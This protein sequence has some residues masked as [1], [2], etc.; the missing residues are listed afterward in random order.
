[1]SDDTNFN[2]E[3]N[4]AENKREFF[5]DN[6]YQ[7]F[8]STSESVQEKNFVTE[9][10]ENCKDATGNIQTASPVYNDAAGRSAAYGQ[11]VSSPV[12]NVK[13]KKE[14][15]PVTF[16]ACVAI[17]SICTVIGCLILAAVLFIATGLPSKL[18]DSLSS[19]SDTSSLNSGVVQ[20][21]SD[22]VVSGTVVESGSNVTINVET[23]SVATAVYAK[24]N[25]SVVGIRVVSS[26]SYAPWA[27]ETYTI[28]GEGSGIVYSSDGI[29]VTNYHVIGDAL[30]T[31]GE[32]DSSYEIRVYLDTSLK[33]YSLAELKGYDVTTDLAVLKIDITGL[34]PLELAE[35]DE[36][37][38]GETAIAIGSPGGLEFMNSVSSGIVSGLNR[39]LQTEDGISYNLIQ[40]TA[41]IN[42]G[43]SGGALLN[44]EGELIG[45]CV[46]KLV[47]TGYE[48]M[49]FAISADTVKDIASQILQSGKV[50]RAY[51]GVTISNNYTETEAKQYNMPAGAWVHS[52]NSD[53]AADKAGIKS[54]DIIVEIEGTY[55]SN[56]YDLRNKLLEYDPGESISVKIYRD[57][58]Y[59]TLTVVLDAQ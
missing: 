50:T 8:F 30:T 3:E 9:N 59:S 58:S 1:M 44:A 28:V 48:S 7:S 32:L 25:Q 15:K 45:I 33:T 49:G 57:G 14:K 51:L 17:S 40:T 11:A 29:I 23:D 53:S 20:S 27:S 36:I 26:S 54:G 18:K 12:K 56:F 21:G 41:A 4:K 42:P 2:P 13:Q 38:I 46:M 10:K 47:S 22:T 24:A 19:K 34:T 37:E 35:V 16:G 39:N 52:V 31:K 55:I 6:N 43:N 5:F